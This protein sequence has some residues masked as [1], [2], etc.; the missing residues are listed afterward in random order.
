[1]RSTSPWRFRLYIQA[2]IILV[3]ATC[4]ISS[5]AADVRLHNVFGDHMV[6]QRNQPI[7]V[8]GWA[9][10]GE[11]VSVTF[12][13]HTASATTNAQGY[14]KV[15]LEAMKADT[16]PRELIA[17]GNNTVKVVDIVIGDVWLCSGQSNMAFGMGACRAEEDI[18]N[19]DL[20]MV[21]YRA[22]FECFAAKP[23]ADL[24]AGNWHRIHPST[25]ASCSGVG[26]Y[27]GRKI[28]KETG[29][30]IGLLESTVGGTEIECWMPPESFRDCPKCSSIGKQ[31]EEAVAQYKEKLPTAVEAMEQWIGPAK[32][33]L[34]EG[35]EIPQPPRIPLHPNVDRGGRWVRIQSLYNGM[36]HP[37]LK[38]PIKGAIW[39]QGE[40]NGREGDQ[41][42]DKKRAMI[43]SWRKLWGHE[44]P[45]YFVQLAAWREPSDDPSGSEEGFQMLRDAQ[46]K[47]LAIP[48]TGMAVSID[49]GEVVSIHPKNKLD[50]GERLALWALAKDY[51][52][53]D[54]VHSGPLYRNAAV[55]DG[56][57]RISFDHVGGGLMVGRKEGR[58]PT[59]EDAGGKL[60]RFAIAGED[61]KWVWADAVIDG[62][63]V[64][65]SSPQVP[66]P[67]A[68]RYAFSMNPQGCNL[69]NKEGLPA[70]PFRTDEW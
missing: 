30:P 43:D 12:G 3:A 7:P 53:T 20:P 22:Y 44:F 54:L 47:C 60:K 32:K 52:K 64:V 2:A 41:Y 4:A 28:F 35:R 37:L 21:R 36:I 39:Y 42:I 70:S 33:A 31:L 65:V 56:K 69:Y 50:V 9:T 58:K 46:R 66:K 67:V 27:F 15:T 68:V 10:P 29:V 34:A 25:S 19:T 13:D 62:D 6:L 57:I 14:W 40:N 17:K 49:V 5:A 59:V 26:F 11:K 51:G 1:M 8:W 55:E 16:T 48:K 18:K 38:F 45:F 24:P 63:T 23:N 61:K